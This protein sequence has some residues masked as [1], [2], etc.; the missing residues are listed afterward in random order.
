MCGLAGI[1][2]SR[3]VVVP[4]PSLRAMADAMSH[5]G[6]DASGTW[7]GPGVGFAH[8][9]LSLFDLSDAATQPWSCGRDALVFNGEI[10]NFAELRGVLESE[11]RQFHTTSDTEVLFA[12]IQAWG[13]DEAL[14]R[15][16]GMFAFVF[17]HSASAT[18][19]LCRDRYGIKPLLYVEGGDGVTFAS[20]AKALMVVSP[21]QVDEMLTLLSL[22][23]LGDK[24]QTRTLFRDVRQVA[25]GSMVV[26]RD[27][28]VVSESAY[29]TVLDHIDEERYRELGKLSFDG[30]C[31]QLG[32]LLEGAVDRM[33]ACDAKLGVFLSGGVDSGLIAAIAA[34]QGHARFA[35]F[36]SDIRGPGSELAQ[37]EEVAR[38]LAIPLHP[39][40]FE[41]NDWAADWVRATWYLETPVITHPSAVPFARVARLAHDHGYKAVLTGE[42][43]DELFLGYPRLASRG[44]ERLAGAP[45]AALRRIYRRV[46]G[47]IDAVLNERDAN[48]F[49]FLRGVAGGFEEEDIAAE[50]MER[51]EFLDPS[52]AR[53]QAVS[54]A[55]AK[56]SLQAL[57]Q[58][59]DR[60]GMSASIESRFP[61]LDE[62]IVAFALNLDARRKLRRTR[63]VHDPKHPF[64]IDKA[65]VRALTE[66]H[67]GPQV[68]TRRKS[69]FPTPG[70]HAVHVR[71]G[72]FAH[73]WSAE[74]FGAGRSFDA[75]IAEWRQP[76][77]I[78]KLM[79]VEIF[80]RLFGWRQ[81]IEEV[82]AYLERSLSPAG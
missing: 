10:Y 40:P 28:R 70:L 78:A 4:D 54:V 25:P 71:P 35:A 3:R 29:S 20:E 27:G 32:S 8:T 48:S 16:R 57:L 7:V 51:Y 62:E 43:A 30:A 60:M 22:R 50:A 11:G 18:T 59:N 56:T 77:D 49:D 26:V 74:A 9:R 14:R 53:L 5:R 36:T 80:G 2:R 21:P 15:I 33:A 55:M 44:V 63:A 69:G 82:E 66:R 37:T 45:V 64:V 39:S 13:V 67:L 79:S 61:F 38:S 12:A 19:F 17:H 75:R 47:L 34:A 68:A 72:A 65:P 76:Y 6:P 42:G 41:P 58:R 31:A 24:F 81:P 23:T 73:G 1:V 46:P 52:Q